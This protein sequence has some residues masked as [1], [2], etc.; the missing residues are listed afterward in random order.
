QDG[1]G[2][3]KYADICHA[4]LGRWGLVAV[5]AALVASQAGFST[6]YLVFIA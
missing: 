5:E 1:S 2:P 4:A 3:V 6:A